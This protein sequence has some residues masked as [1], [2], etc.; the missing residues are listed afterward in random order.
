MAAFLFFFR[1][2][3][4]F[5]E[6]FEGAGSFPTG[7]FPFG[8]DTDFGALRVPDFS[9]PI[10]DH[11]SSSQSCISLKLVVKSALLRTVEGEQRRADRGGVHLRP[12]VAAELVQAEFGQHGVGTLRGIIQIG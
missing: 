11:G 7:S 10:T 6:H 5:W 4:F 1:A 9:P 3:E 8:S 12:H 2:Y